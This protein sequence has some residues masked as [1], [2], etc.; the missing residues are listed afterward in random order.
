MNYKKTFEVICSKESKLIFFISLDNIIC[1][2]IVHG[3][4]LIK[5]T[6]SVISVS[7][8]MKEEAFIQMHSLMVVEKSPWLVIGL[9]AQPMKTE[10]TFVNACDFHFYKNYC[11][12]SSVSSGIYV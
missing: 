8:S 1:L 2:C 12:K 6:C 7:Y 9:T 11:T 10:Y 4:D 5:P 3:H